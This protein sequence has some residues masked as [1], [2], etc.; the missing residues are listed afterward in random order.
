MGDSRLNQEVH[1]VAMLF[2]IDF[3]DHYCD[4]SQRLNQLEAK[5][6]GVQVGKKTRYI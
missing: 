4:P 5:K 3:H 1:P 6:G 2:Y